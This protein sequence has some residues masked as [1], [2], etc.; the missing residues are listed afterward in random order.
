MVSDI[1]ACVAAH[2][3]FII[4]SVLLVLLVAFLLWFAVGWIISCSKAHW[5]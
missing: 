5:R 2:V 4:Y 1:L 3:T